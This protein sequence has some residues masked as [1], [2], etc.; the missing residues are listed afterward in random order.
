MSLNYRPGVVGV[1]KNKKNMVLVGERSDALG[2]WQFPQGGLQEGEDDRDGIKREMKEEVGVSDFK[3]IIR[4]SSTTEY[5]F[6]QKLSYPEDK[7][8]YDG[9]SHRWFLLEF[10]ST[11]EDFLPDTSNIDDEFVNFKWVSPQEAYDNIVSWKKESYKKG[12]ALLGFSVK[13]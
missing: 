3:I 8:P 4:S 1:F 11:Q 5:L 7:A 9:Q 10:N 13:D 6:P 12:L 2:Q